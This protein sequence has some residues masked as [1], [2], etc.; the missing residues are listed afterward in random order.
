MPNTEMGPS[1]DPTDAEL[2]TVLNY[3]RRIPDLEKRAAHAL[4]DA[5]DYVLLG[6]KTGR[7][8]IAQLTRQEKAHIGTQVEIWLRRE[9]LGN[10]EGELLDAKIAGIEVDIKNTI[11]ENWMIPH[12]A[13]GQLC[14]LITLNEVERCF[15]IGLLRCN[16]DRLGA[17]NQDGKRGISAAARKEIEWILNRAVLPVSVFLDLDEMNR[18]AIFGQTSGQRRVRELFLRVTQKPISWSDIAVVARQRDVR[19]RARDA[20]TALLPL[21]FKILC[22]HWL[23]GRKKAAEAGIELLEDYWVSIREGTVS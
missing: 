19:A 6:E 8:S 15:S 1:A 5:I 13:V 21:G 7:Y 22:G 11:G 4:R 12:E 2:Q 9:I 17:T 23:A 10:V 3:I 16:L 18:E 20:G 14:L